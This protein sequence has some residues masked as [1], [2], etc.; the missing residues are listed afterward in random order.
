MFDFNFSILNS[1][2]DKFHTTF[3]LDASKN[4][5]YTVL[6][7]VYLELI[8]CVNSFPRYSPN[9]Y[10][11]NFQGPPY[12]QL[13]AF[14]AVI[15]SLDIQIEHYSNRLKSPYLSD[16]ELNALRECILER[17]IARR[18]INDIEGRYYIAKEKYEKFLRENTAKLEL[19]ANPNVL[20]CLENFNVAVHNAFISGNAK[21]DI[22][23]ER[24]LLKVALRK[25]I[26][27]TVIF[28]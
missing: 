25:D 9:F 22:E 28:G 20:Q 12:Y 13:E 21:D 24:N 3:M 15:Q 1:I 17:S 23:N 11:K 2:V 6:N 18:N 7:D 26:N 14:S 8:D 16:M 19:H 4:I 27:K 10:L 5:R